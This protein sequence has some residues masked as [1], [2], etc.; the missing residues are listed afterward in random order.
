MVKSFENEVVKGKICR[1][2]ILFM[3]NFAFNF[4]NLTIEG[5]VFKKIK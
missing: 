4:S 2:F 5:V 3:F 1:P